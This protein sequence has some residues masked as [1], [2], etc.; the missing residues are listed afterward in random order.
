[1]EPISKE[2]VTML[3]AAMETKLEWITPILQTI[4]VR[5]ETGDLLGPGGDS[6]GSAS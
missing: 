5:S 6:S 2:N 4:F 3:G 1:M